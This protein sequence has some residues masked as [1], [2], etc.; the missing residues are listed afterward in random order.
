[1]EWGIL[2][3]FACRIWN[4]LLTAQGNEELFQKFDLEYEFS[5]LTTIV[6]FFGRQFFVF[7]Q[8][9]LGMWNF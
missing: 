8:S 4:F 7:C 9:P 5:V 2:S 3:L 6:E 1:M